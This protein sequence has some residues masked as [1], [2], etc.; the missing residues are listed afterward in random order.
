LRQRGI[1]LLT[2]HKSKKDRPFA[3]GSR[4]YSCARAFYLNETEMKNVLGGGCSCQQMAIEFLLS[5]ILK[6]VESG[7]EMLI[8]S[9][10]IMHF[11]IA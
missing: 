6:Q 3:E 7:S 8:L 11:Y 9:M 4:D 1:G 5:S 2:Q 10:Y